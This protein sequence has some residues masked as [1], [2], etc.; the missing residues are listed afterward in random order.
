M[1]HNELA[2]LSDK[3]QSFYEIAEESDKLVHIKKLISML[4]QKRQL[5]FTMHRMEG[6]SY[7][8][9]SDLLQISPRTVEDHLSKSMKYLHENSKHIFNSPL[10][11]A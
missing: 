11:K 2:I 5:V 8:E 4:P 9:I 7:A 6:F 1:E 10:T 3:C